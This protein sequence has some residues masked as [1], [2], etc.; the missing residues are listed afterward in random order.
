MTDPSIAITS[1][2]P[3]EDESALRRLLTGF[4]DWM[5]DHEERYEPEAEL[6]EDFRSLERDTESWAWI[7]RDE[8]TPVGCVL[9]YGE[10]DDLA[11]FRRLWVIPAYRGFGIGRALT[12][13][14]IDTARAQGYQT[15]GLTTPPWAETAQA[16]YESMGFERT[17]PYPETRLPERHHDD[18]IFMRLDLTSRA[19]N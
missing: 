1:A 10:T 14:V 2:D 16:L 5:V 9:M 13:V 11:E 6:A 18:A 3:R 7:A 4:H 19:R 15:L 12:S 8:G 17:P